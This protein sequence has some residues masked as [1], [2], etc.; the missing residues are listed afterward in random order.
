MRQLHISVAEEDKSKVTS[1]LDDHGADYTALSEGDS[2]HVF[3]PVPTPA[4]GDVLNAIEGK[5]IGSDAYSVV[6]R[7]EFAETP[8]LPDLQDRYSSTVQSLSKQELQGKIREIQWP[9]QIYY[10]GTLL[11]VIAAAAGLL[12]DLP[13]LII[14][15]MIIAPQVSSA[16]AVPAGAVLGDWKMVTSSVRDQFLGLALGIAGAAAFAFLLR[17]FGF[18]S[19]RLAVTNLELLGLRASPTMLSTLG[20]VVAGIVGAFGYTTEQS[21]SLIGVMVAAAIIPAV[22]AVGIGI[23]WSLP[24]FTYG[25]FLLLLVNLLSINV[26]AAATLVAMGYLPEWWTDDEPHLE[27]FRESMPSKSRTSV[28]AVLAFVIVATA[29]TGVLTGMNIAF[30]QNTTQEVEETLSQPAYDSLTL[31]A[32]QPAYGGPPQTSDPIEVTV[33]VS[34]STDESYPDLASRLERGIERR[35]GQDVKV[36]VEFTGT[37]TAE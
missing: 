33:S 12:V 37:R 11:S 3:S 25:A 32:V 6:T 1:V 28:Y 18:V 30:S 5:D 4:V 10:I 17:E 8:K 35:T 19:T 2:V 16:L 21:T 36:V 20:A 26:G 29:G 13:A 22:A 7:A 14:G 27:S 23:A 24:V 31:M 15:S 9:Y 34:H